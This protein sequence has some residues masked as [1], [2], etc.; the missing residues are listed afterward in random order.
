MMNNN[1]STM[2]KKGNQRLYKHLQ[3]SAKTTASGFLTVFM[4]KTYTLKFERE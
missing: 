1:E 2:I 4:D 3:I